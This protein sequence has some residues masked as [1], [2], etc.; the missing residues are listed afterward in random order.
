MKKIFYLIFI[1]LIILTL[2]GCGNKTELTQEDFKNYAL[3]NNLSLDNTGNLYSENANVVSFINAYND[4]IAFTFYI[5]SN[6]EAAKYMFKDIKS[7]EDGIEKNKE[8]YT[9]LFNYNKYSYSN[10]N[11]YYSIIRV[12]KTLLMTNTSSQNE[13]NAK[14]IIKELGY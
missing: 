6:N 11:M 7:N 10:D 14:N 1:S 4:S 2:S 3:N 13:E 5:C 12:G 8:M 9:N